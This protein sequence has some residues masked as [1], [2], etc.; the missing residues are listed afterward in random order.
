M[1]PIQPR[2]EQPDQRNRQHRGIEREV[3][4][5]RGRGG[6]WRGRQGDRR[7]RQAAPLDAERSFTANSAHELR[8]PVAA[9]LA[10]IRRLKAEPF[11]QASARTVEIATALQRLARLSEKLLQ[12]AEAEGAGLL[13]RLGRRRAG[14]GG[15]ASNQ[16][17]GPSDEQ[18]AQRAR[19]PVIASL[20]RRRP[21]A[22]W[23]RSEARWR[24]SPTLNTRSCG[25][26]RSD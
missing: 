26:C 9:A 7:R 22:S 15:E 18:A 13:E 19:I 5:F 3:R 1:P 21:A 8:T 14:L 16:G 25:T 6:Q 10:Q 20:H 17:M 24:P 11:E 2:G 4:K 23:P 12:L